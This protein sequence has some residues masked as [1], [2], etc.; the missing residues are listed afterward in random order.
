MQNQVYLQFYV[1]IVF[2]LKTVAAIMY[3][4]CAPDT[5]ATFRSKMFLKSFGSSKIRKSFV[6]YFSD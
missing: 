4:S 1:L 5:R 3:T 6:D 2:K